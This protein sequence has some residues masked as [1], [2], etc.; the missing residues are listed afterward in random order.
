MAPA[1]RV[2]VMR[3]L[4]MVVCA[5]LVVAGP[6][7][8]QEWTE[9]QN[10]PDG[11]RVSF[12]G[13]P[14]ITETTWKTQFDYTIP[15]RVYSAEHGR[16]RY[17]LTVVDYTALEPLGIARRKACPAGAE[18]CIGSD[19]SGPGFWKHDVRGAMIFASS[20]FI[21]RDAKVTHF[22]W[23]HEDLVE[24]LQLQLTNNADQSRTFVYISMHE[25]K[26]YVLEGTVPKGYPPPALIQQSMGYL[27]K[28]GNLVRYQT[29]YSN[30]IYGLRDREPP[31]YG[32]GG[33]GA[34]RGGAG[35]G[36]QGGGRRGGGAGD[37]Q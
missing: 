25:M 1:G 27:D 26:L 11:F 16:E 18:P 10:V 8:A 30:E 13:P 4:A 29:I 34:G 24:G 19:L 3:K 15:A 35:R 20:Q 9:Y 37:A 7:M 6:A 31:T 21:Q 33:G 28:N 2:D 32:G 23:S 36:G 14:K 22:L 5:V 17:S 12:P